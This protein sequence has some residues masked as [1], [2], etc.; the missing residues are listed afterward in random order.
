MCGD[1]EAVETA[2]ALFEAVE[3]AVCKGKGPDGSPAECSLYR[4]CAYQRQKHTKP[5]VWIAAHNMLWH[6]QPVLGE[7]CAVV[8]DEGFC[9]TAIREPAQITL[10][11]FRS[12]PFDVN[13][14]SACAD[15]SG[16]RSR[17]ARAVDCQN[18][19]VGGLKREHLLAVGM[20]PKLCTE[21]NRLEWAF[22]P[23]AALYPGMA[24][25]ARKAA[26]A[27]AHGARHI[28]RRSAVWK[29]IG[30]FLSLPEGE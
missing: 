25:S 1:L 28:G 20:T 26:A 14:I 6:A 21:A 22:K 3:T 8:I 4:V 7:A 30:D 19:N 9:K 10:D 27:A 16:H 18:G 13:R 2:Q 23:K 11:E 15:L 24:P 12:E 5:D 17:L 29:A